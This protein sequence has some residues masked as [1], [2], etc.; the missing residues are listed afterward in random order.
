MK[1]SK[2]SLPIDSHSNVREEYRSDSQALDYSVHLQ[3]LLEYKTMQQMANETDS[4]NDCFHI[5]QTE[6]TPLNFSLSSSL[7][8]LHSTSH[9]LPDLS[10][11]D[12]FLLKPPSKLNKGIKRLAKSSSCILTG[13][14]GETDDNQIINDDHGFDL[15][16]ET[17]LMFSRNSTPDSLSSFQINFCDVDPGCGS[18]SVISEYR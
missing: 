4:N 7:V 9:L 2:F 18:V 17:P 15:E 6:D 8:D 16:R 5:Y 3:Q 13:N 14:E 11:D 10:E 1:P 12:H